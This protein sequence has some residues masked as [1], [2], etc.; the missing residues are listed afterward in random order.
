MKKLTLSVVLVLMLLLSLGVFSASAD[1]GTNPIATGIACVNQDGVGGTF[2][3]DFYDDTGAKVTSLSNQSIDA[4]GSALYFTTSIAGLPS[5]FQGSAV[6]SSGVNLA[7]SVNTQTTTGTVRVGTSNGVGTADTGTKLY[8]PQIL[9]NLGGFD[10]IFAVQNTGASAANVTIRYYNSSGSE[11]FNH[12]LSVPAYSSH[13]FDQSGDED[14]DSNPDLPAGFIGSAT[15][16][17]TAA[18]AGTVIMSASG[19]NTTSAQ[20][21]AYNAA[22]GGSLVVHAPRVAKNLSGV[23][24]TSGLS[25][26]NVGD[27]PTNISADFKVFDQLAGTNKTATLSKTGVGP[28]QSWAVFLGST[29]NATL[30]GISRF[31]GS[32]TFTST[33]EN[34]VCTFNEDVRTPFSL[35]GQGSTYNGFADGSQ[36]T[37]VFFSQIVDLGSASFQGGFQIA[38]TEDTAGSCDYLFTDSDGK[39]LSVPDNP[40]AKNG[41][42]SVFAPTVFSNNG[43]SEAGK[44]NGSAVV[45]C[46]VD[47][48]G[49]YNLTGFGFTGDPFITNNGINQ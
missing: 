2:N 6:V 26:Q 16:E 39:T 23:G 11:V 25:C 48:L 7:C 40:I 17:S 43:F 8:A 33:V 20:Y 5:G 19:A 24:Y 41:S 1:L 15:A 34:I 47:V 44:F 42:V 9:N 45:T 49:I 46:D 35:A 21:L 13:V 31:F 10:S 29:G 28:G 37:T 12:T 27:D 22:A 14:N 30:D 36:S 32:A 4:N 18:L 3:I 38:N